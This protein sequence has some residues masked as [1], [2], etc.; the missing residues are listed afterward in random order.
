M[1]DNQADLTTLSPDDELDLDGF[2]LQPFEDD[3]LI[4][5]ADIVESTN[6]RRWQIELQPTTEVEQVENIP[7]GVIRDSGFLTH[8]DRDDLVRIG[9][10]SLK[11]VFKAAL[12][13]TN[14]SI[15][16]LEG[17]TVHARVTEDD[18][19]FARARGYRPAQD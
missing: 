17:E 6:G 8:D 4:V 18:N 9:I 11:R 10:T 15:K 2:G 19:G 7:G 5:S 1:S 12:G 3:F 13:R 16:E 14:A